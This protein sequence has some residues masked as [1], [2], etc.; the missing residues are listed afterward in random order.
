[1]TEDEL[2]EKERIQSK[3]ARDSARQKRQSE[4]EEQHDLLE[5]LLQ[6]RLESSI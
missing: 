1:M 4:R 6:G 2:R 5:Y 3:M